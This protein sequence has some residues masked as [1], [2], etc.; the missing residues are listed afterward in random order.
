MAATENVTEAPVST[1]WLAGGVVM[2]GAVAGTVTVSVAGGLV[3]EP[4][5]LLTVTV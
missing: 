2:A 1:D 3:T 5:L 4:A